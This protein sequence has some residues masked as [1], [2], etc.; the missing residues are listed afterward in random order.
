[1]C[2]RIEPNL[3]VESTKLPKNRINNGYC[4]W[5]WSQ[6]YYYPTH[7]SMIQATYVINNNNLLIFMQNQWPDF[8]K[9]NH[10]NNKHIILRLLMRIRPSRHLSNK[11][12]LKSNGL[13]KGWLNKIVFSV[14]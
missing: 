3:D 6:W 14:A 1:M 11:Q 7:L 2:I 4:I 8:L 12:S 10:K 5:N 13:C 9:Q